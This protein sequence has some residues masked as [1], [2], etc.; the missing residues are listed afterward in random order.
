MCG[1]Y[2]NVNYRIIKKYYFK[3]PYILTHLSG[4]NINS[5]CVCTAKAFVLVLLIHNWM[6]VGLILTWLWKKEKLGNSYYNPVT[7]VNLKLLNSYVHIKQLNNYPYYNNVWNWEQENFLGE[8]FSVQCMF[9]HLSINITIQF[10]IWHCG[11][12]V[13]IHVFWDITPYLLVSIHVSKLLCLNLQKQAVLRSISPLTFQ[14]L[15]LLYGIIYQKTWTP[16]LI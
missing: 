3:H 8:S 1:W 6:N 15:T 5:S 10:E 13:T 16:R 14:L 4:D 11:N 12:I 2:F 9:A 7:F